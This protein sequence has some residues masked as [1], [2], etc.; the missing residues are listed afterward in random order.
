[1]RIDRSARAG[2]GG[3]LALTQVLDTLLFALSPSD[4]A[5]FITAIA[6]L[7]T[8]ALAAAATAQVLH[9]WTLRRWISVAQYV[10]SGGLAAVCRRNLCSFNGL[11]RIQRVRIPPHPSRHSTVEYSYRMR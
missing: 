6:A 10:R 3:A 4:P 9:S 8:A 5:T 11:A 7:G 1:M 2:A